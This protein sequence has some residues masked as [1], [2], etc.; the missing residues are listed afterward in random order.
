MTVIVHDDSALMNREE[1]VAVL[2]DMTAS[3]IATQLYQKFGL[4]PEVD[5][6]DRWVR[7]LDIH[8]RVVVSESPG[9]KLYLI[10]RS[11]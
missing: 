11:D 10:E 8:H 7:G 1:T 5:A 4:T 2:E 3:D 6:V 9:P